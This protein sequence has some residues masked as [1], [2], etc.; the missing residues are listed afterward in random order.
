MNEIETKKKELLETITK[1]RKQN[2]ELIKLTN[3]GEHPDENIVQL[4][5]YDYILLIQATI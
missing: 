5:I 1:A 4:R 2:E 3:D